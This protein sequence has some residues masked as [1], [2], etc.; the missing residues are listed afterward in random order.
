[1]TTLTSTGEVAEIAQADQFQYVNGVPLSQYECGY[2][3]V[4][5]ARSMAPPGEAPTLTP[6]QII[7]G[8]E[9]AYAQ[10][11]GSDS[12][13]NTNGMTLQQLYELLAQVGLHYQATALDATTLHTW[14]TLGYPVLVAIAETSVHDLALGDRVPYPWTPAGTHI[15][16]LTGNAG[17][18]FLVRDSANVGSLYD[19][20]SLRPGPRTYDA[21][22]L[23][24]VSATVVVP[25]WRPRP[26]DGD[27]SHQPQEVD[28]LDISQVSDYFVQIDSTHWQRKDNPAITLGLGLLAYYCSFGTQALALFGLPL[29]DEHLIPDASGKLLQNTAMQR[30]ER[31]VPAWDPQHQVDRPPYAGDYFC[32]HIDGTGP[33]CDPRIP[34]LEAELLAAQQAAQNSNSGIGAT[35]TQAVTEIKAIVDKITL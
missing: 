15:I 8:A 26:T 23:Q 30:C 13:G 1:M 4:Y 11:D 5:L 10:Y 6:A 19:P 29:E 28:V 34:Q 33:G 20:S 35:C 3:G 27:P 9:A 21:A 16:L 14:L 2:Y 12:V 31:A 7:S 32:L 24:F 22:Q 25:P 17:D 18:N